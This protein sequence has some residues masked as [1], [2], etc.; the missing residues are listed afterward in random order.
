MTTIRVG[1]PR[2][3]RL[4]R[5]RFHDPYKMVSKPPEPCICPVCKAVFKGGRWQW[6]KSWPEKAREEICQA[7]RRIRDAYPAGILILNG[8][9]VTT[10]LAE[11]MNLARNQEAD[12]RA[13]HPLHRILRVS[14]RHGTVT[15]CTTDIHLPERIGKALRRAYKGRF[16]INHEKQG[17]FVRA[18]WT[19]IP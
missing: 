1:K 2:K 4:I 17:C 12:E 19:S 6:L 10:H 18:C 3:D 11:L 13:E 16:E 15:I 8:S 5:E 7:C 9:L 14:R